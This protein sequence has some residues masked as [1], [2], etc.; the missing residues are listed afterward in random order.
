MSKGKIGPD[1]EIIYDEE[2]PKNRRNNLL[3]AII[4]AVALII[5]GALGG[6]FI[7]NVVNNNTVDSS[8]V[9]ATPD[10]VGATQVAIG[11]TQTAISQ[12]TRVGQQS[13]PTSTSKP[14][15]TAVPS[16]IPVSSILYQNDFESGRTDDLRTESGIWRVVTEDSGNRVLQAA[17]DKDGWWSVA[18][19]GSDRWTDYAVEL[20]FRWITFGAMSVVVRGEQFVD[21]Y[22]FSIHKDGMSLTQMREDT[23]NGWQHPQ[24][25]FDVPHITNLDFNGWNTVCT[26]VVNDSIRVAVNGTWLSD[27]FDTDSDRYSRGFVHL[28]SDSTAVVWYDEI[29]VW[30]LQ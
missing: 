13:T 16:E 6:V 19:I 15:V 4:G 24:R 7:T 3:V 11:L 10:V 30:S 26:L 9:T 21:G 27:A 17:S 12:P 2:S 29:R 23:N 1:G 18:H 8:V 25:F 5:S 20:R 22:E 28:L 14:P